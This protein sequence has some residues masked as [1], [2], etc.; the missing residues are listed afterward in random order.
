MDVLLSYMAFIQTQGLIKKGIA[1][2]SLSFLN[3]ALLLIGVFGGGTTQPRIFS[4]TLHVIKGNLSSRWASAADHGASLT[5][6]SAEWTSAS[7]PSG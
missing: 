2:F 4:W 6:Q 7:C 5:T 1:I 3:S